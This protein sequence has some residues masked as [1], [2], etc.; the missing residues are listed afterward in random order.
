MVTIREERTDRYENL[1]FSDA[2]QKRISLIIHGIIDEN[3]TQ[4]F[5][6]YGNRHYIEDWDWFQ[7]VALHGL[8]IYCHK[9]SDQAVFDSLVSFFSG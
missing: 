9:T 4:A 8:Y 1:D 2:L 3:N 6:G 5:T 7:G